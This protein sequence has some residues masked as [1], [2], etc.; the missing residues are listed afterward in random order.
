MELNLEHVAITRFSD[1]SDKSFEILNLNKN[2][3]RHIPP[4]FLPPTLKHLSLDINDIHHLELNSPLPNLLTLS[5]NINELRHIDMDITLPVLHT[6]SAKSNRL[7]N[8]EFL[9]SMPS[10]KNLIIGQNNIRVL[11]NLPNSLQS[12]QANFNKI[13]MVQ[14]RLPPGLL[15]LNLL[16]NSLRNGSLPLHWPTSLRVL[17]LSYNSLTEFPK[18]LPDGLEDLRLVENMIETIPSKLPSKLIRLTLAGNKIRSLPETMNVQL[19][20]LI[21][22]K[23]RLTQDF[24]KKQV[25][26]TNYFFEEDNWNKTEHHIAQTILRR[27]WK[28]YL[29]KIRLRHIARSRRIYDEL[30]V[31]SLHPDHILQTDTFSWQS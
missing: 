31:V 15:E 30:L 19:E 14:S 13:Q 3:L 7:S 5:I 11:E 2:Y 27:C 17:N 20:V 22:S 25:S 12:I 28:R 9:S 4:E 16:G 23:N 21:V 8:L 24:G 1:I 6:L 18:K 26:W 10:L 29:L